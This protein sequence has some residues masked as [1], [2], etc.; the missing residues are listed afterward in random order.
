[1]EAWDL[2][3]MGSRLVALVDEVLAYSLLRF[4]ESDETLREQLRRRASRAVEPHPDASKVFLDCSAELTDSD[5][6]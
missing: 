5:A 6:F 4:A 1:M 2:A 3:T